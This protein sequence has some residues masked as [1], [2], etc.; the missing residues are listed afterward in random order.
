MAEKNSILINR[1]HWDLTASDLAEARSW[2]DRVSRF[3]QTNLPALLEGVF[4]NYNPDDEV[5]FFNR[6]EIDLGNL[7]NE[8]KLADRMI[9]T[10]RE[11]I[12]MQLAT[13]GNPDRKITKRDIEKVLVEQLHFYLL[14]GYLPWNGSPESFRSPSELLLCLYNLTEFHLDKWIKEI[15]SDHAARIRLIEFFS[16]DELKALLLHTGINIE[17]LEAYLKFIN[18]LLLEGGEQTARRLTVFY[19]LLKYYLQLNTI[20][21]EELAQRWWHESIQQDY[22]TLGGLQR[23]RTVLENW[24]V[25]IVPTGSSWSSYFGTVSKHIASAFDREFGGVASAMDTLEDQPMEVD[26]FGEKE[27]KPPGVEQ[28]SFFVENA[29]IVLVYPYLKE[30]FKIQNL[31]DSGHQFN[32]KT[33]QLKAVY[34]LQCIAC[35]EADVKEYQLVLPKVLCGYAVEEPVYPVWESGT[36]GGEAGDELLKKAI[37]N[38]P[39]VQ[40]T[41]VAGFR[42]SFLL[43][44]GRLSEEEFCWLLHVER[45][46]WDVLLGSLSYPLSV[47]KL[48][49]MSKPLYIQW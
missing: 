32:S 27:M 47:I 24:S 16:V 49:W 14:H 34:W 48:P 15:A 20:G 1:I 6:L 21:V 12:D 35:G 30:F 28:P 11:V 36:P 37:G 29:G 33:D 44:Q 8:S 18:S 43:R 39:K 41:S 46:G 45:K 38:W 22:F 31:T 17:L 19:P 23:M 9:D 4:K 3:S 10:L 26:T 13:N 2:Q 7:E 40:N 5:V 42:N 25:A